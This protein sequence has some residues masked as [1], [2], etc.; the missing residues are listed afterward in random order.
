MA[1]KDPVCGMEIDGERAAGTTVFGG[2][3]PYFFC[4]TACKIAFDREPATYDA[5]ARRVPPALVR[6]LPL[7][8]NLWWS[9]H[10]EARALFEALGTHWDPAARDNPIQLLLKASPEALAARSKDAEYL[11]RYG[12]VVRAFDAEV[13]ASP[14][15]SPYTGRLAGPIAYF[16]AEFE[17]HSTLPIY[18]GG[19]GVLAGDITKEASDLGLP[20]IGVGF[21]YPQGYFRQA[22][23]GDGWQEERYETLERALAPAEPAC[24]VSGRACAVFLDLPDRRVHAAVWRVA[25]G[26]VSLY[27]MDTDLED[28]PP[29]DRELSSRLYAGDHEFRLRQEILLGIGGV[30]LLRAL[31]LAPAVWHAN[32]GHSAFMLVERVRELVETGRPFEQAVDEVRASSVFTTHTPVAAGHDT[33][34]FPLLDR[35]LAAYWPTLGLNRERFLALGVDPAGSDTG[36]NMTALALRLSGVRNA[37]SRRHGEVSRRMWRGLWPGVAESEV[38][39]LSITNGVH[40]PSWLAP[41]LADLYGKYLGEGWLD[42][43]GDPATW[44]RLDEVPDRELWEAHVTLKRRLCS[45][46]RERARQR[47]AGGSAPLAAAAGAFLDP[48][49]LT[50]GF[51]RRFATYKRATL[52]FRDPGRLK[53]LMTDPHHPVQVVFAGK[54]HPSDEPGKEALHA[55]YRAAAD[56]AYAGRIAFVEDYG[57]HVARYLVQG[58]DV[59]LNTP[60]PPL[61]ASGTSGQKAALNGIPNL[62]VLDGWWFEAYDGSNGWAFGDH[63]QTARDPDDAD[64]ADADALY[65]VLEN[66]VVPL[67]YARPPGGV[68]AGWVARMRRSIQTLAPRFST[69]RMLKEH[70]DRCYAGP[71][72]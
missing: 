50:L 48:G 26:R 47:W 14:R 8:R 17:V 36:F 49:A 18:S 34:P 53:A 2:S 70:V 11:A 65:R 22:V 55:V 4:S 60:R 20:V 44:R 43:H 56:P 5:L 25:V 1:V 58:V 68:S 19:L 54:A 21:M 38:P 7:A 15:A 42:R 39:I 29:W 27:L 16:S 71:R 10:P 3:T 31:G 69:R 9:W 52:M 51:A 59:W 62:S 46:L 12:Q 33:F 6:L 37:V 67:F 13:N 66:E 57:M 35:Y 45:F 72:T 24:T 64:R 23:T 41:E 30:R 40:L 61:E 28:N 32:E 63:D